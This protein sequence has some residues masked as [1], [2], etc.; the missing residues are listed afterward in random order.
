VRS[1]RHRVLWLAAVVV[2]LATGVI[3]GSLALSGP[4]VSGL[5][6]DKGGLQQQI[7][8]LGEQ[9][10]A[11]SEKLAAA[12]KFDTEMAGRIVRDALAGKSVVLFR[13]PD[14]EDADIE[15]MSRLI[16][17]A[18]GTVAASVGLTDEFVHGNASE[19][20]Q[21]VVN[22]PIVPAGAKLNTTLTDPG[23]QAGDL[24]GIA[25]LINRDPKIAPV[26]DAA[27]DTVLAA[28]RDTG[29]LTYGDP[30]RAAD[31]AVVV[32]GGA[33]PEDA[34]NQGLTVARFAAALAPH[35]S[36][37]VLAGRDGSAT[38]VSAV[39]VARG[40]AALANAVTTV[41]DIGRESNRISTVLTLQTMI[42]GPAPAGQ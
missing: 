30:P 16:G 14:A 18:G 33:L 29:F 2:A 24:L 23:A 20:L 4:L 22:S 15:A 11:L 38:G 31:T 7:T 6:G 19:K 3:L 1:G 26:D 9:N 25:L 13:T 35:G 8:S 34:G 5:R 17:Q 10:R 21:S 37:I 27:R 42:G 32:T 12:D 41:D 39:A 36:G 28:L 40:D